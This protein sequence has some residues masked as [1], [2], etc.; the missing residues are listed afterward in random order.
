MKLFS[1][2]QQRAK[3]STDATVVVILRPHLC[4]HRSTIN[5]AVPSDLQLILP[6]TVVVSE[7][8][9][10]NR[11]VRCFKRALL[12]QLD[13]ASYFGGH[14]HLSPFASPSPYKLYLNQCKKP[15]SPGPTRL[16]RRRPAMPGFFSRFFNKRHGIC[17]ALG[18]N[19]LSPNSSRAFQRSVNRQELCQ[20]QTI[21]FKRCTFRSQHE[22]GYR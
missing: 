12:D 15:Q 3:M 2:H 21:V 1:R 5:S 6:A 13:S 8:W 7:R 22:F 14:A 18:F 17:P 20:K 11:H 4:L 19:N 10:L 16:I 9:S